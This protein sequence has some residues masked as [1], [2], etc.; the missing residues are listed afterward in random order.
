MYTGVLV[1]L[2]FT[3]LVLYTGAVSLKY[4]IIHG[5]FWR[6]WNRGQSVCV[7]SFILAKCILYSW[8]CT[9][10]MFYFPFIFRLFLCNIY[11]K[12]SLHYF[13]FP[14]YKYDPYST[15]I[16]VFVK[17]IHSSW[18]TEM[19]PNFTISRV[20]YDI[21]KSLKMK[22][23]HVTIGSFDRPNLFYNVQP[24]DRGNA[25]LDKLVKEISTYVQKACSTI[26]YC[27]TIK[28]TE[29]VGFPFPL[30]P[31]VILTILHLIVYMD[32]K[33]KN[34]FGMIGSPVYEHT[35]HIILKSAHKSSWAL[36]WLAFIFMVL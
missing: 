10:G 32:F 14:I 8:S 30:F 28:D 12:L 27:T 26:V 36:W 33:L 20:R 3:F 24:F 31:S 17:K 6:I 1:R 7:L 4:E 19:K 5:P 16:L 9:T 2:N 13:Q 15:L 34:L 22:S 35:T 29:Q 23:P 18:S 25:F 21:M 11:S